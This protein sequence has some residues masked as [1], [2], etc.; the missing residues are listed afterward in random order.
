M[1]NPSKNNIANINN[2]SNILSYSLT[3]NCLVSI[4]YYDL[5][6]RVIGKFVN[7]EQNAGSYSMNLPIMNYAKGTYFQVFKAGNYTKTGEVKVY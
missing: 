1:L 2:Y 4:A 5:Q 6:G 7:K 3:N